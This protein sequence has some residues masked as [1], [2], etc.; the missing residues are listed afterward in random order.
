MNT[1]L[2]VCGAGASS[3]FV[4][5]RIRAAAAS[6]GVPV[7]VE[8]GSTDDL[9]DRLAGVGVLLVGSHL[10]ELFDALAA[11]ADARGVRAALLPSTVLSA[12]GPEAALDLATGLLRPAFS[13]HQP[14][15]E[16]SPHG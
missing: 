13:H 5:S 4:A 15:T 3:T 6:A 16:G 1:I 11:D 10:A 9:P 2:I 14:T 12:G 7:T 8:A